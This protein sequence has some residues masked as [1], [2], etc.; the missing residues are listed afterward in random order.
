MRAS[1]A[2]SEI[3]MPA[4]GDLTATD[5]VVSLNRRSGRCRHPRS[6]PL[7]R[8]APRF[9]RLVLVGI[10][11]ALTMGAA[12]ASS[13]AR[14]VRPDRTFGSGRGWVATR[15]PG[16]SSVAYGVAVIRGGGIV[17]AGQATTAD[18]NGQILVVRY[19]P[20]GRRDRSFGSHGIFKTAL[21]AADG[22]FTALSVVPERSTGRLLIAGGY[23]QGSM[24]ALR[25]TPA[26][27]LDRTFGR[28]RTGLVTTPAGGIA[29][30][31]AVQPN[32]GILLGGSNF[33]SE[34]R[35]MVVAGFTRHGR[36]DR[37]FGRGGLAQ[38]LFWNPVLASSAGVT[39]L[40]TTP[41]GGV[42]AS[43]HIDYIGSD[44]HGSAGVFRLSS[45]GRPVR[46]FGTGG[47]VEVAFRQPGPRPFAFWFPCAM[48]V[49]AR[50]R[51]TVTGDGTIGAT[52]ALLSARLR[53]RGVFDRSF[54]RARNGRVVTPGL[55]GGDD[56]TCGATASAAGSLIVGVGSTLVK[57]RPDGAANTGF[58]RGGVLRIAK[59]PQV[60]INA[61]A[62][63]GSRRVVVAGSAGDRVYVARYLRPR[64]R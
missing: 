14:R 47:H 56:T 62:R 9:S 4:T 46:S 55:R 38:A 49:D 53:P 23:G 57:L 37:R 32:G 36:L 52:A 3:F 54:G 45:H 12:P 48:T 2:R 42:I 26:G 43:G 51:I 20:D 11:V 41:N 25:L 24:L 33:N 8:P 28:A 5:S 15:I 22:P 40:A 19:R 18:G 7:A 64:R 35:P 61:V 30:S 16:A 6:R 17:I 60:E 50:G 29:E 58:A 1:D 13:D 10:A 39:G 21:P 59:P 34:G 63:S 27:R 44:G 31:L